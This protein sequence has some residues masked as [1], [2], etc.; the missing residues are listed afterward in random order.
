MFT[1]F[2]LIV[3]FAPPILG[4]LLRNTPVWWLPSTGLLIGGG[5]CFTQF[6]TTSHGEDAALA[7][8]GNFVLVAM[9]GALLVYGFVLL[10][11]TAG[12]RRSQRRRTP[13]LPAPLPVATVVAMSEH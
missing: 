3:L 13:P 7:G 12:T 8:L 5:A 11:I 2:V 10:L 6:D 1:A 4:Y 9:G